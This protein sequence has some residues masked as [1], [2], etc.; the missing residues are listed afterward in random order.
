MMILL[1]V[2]EFAWWA[3]AWSQEIAPAPFIAPYL[4]GAGVT[5]GAALALRLVSRRD[6]P[7]KLSLALGVVVVA[8]SA[9]LFLPL[10]FAIP[11]EIPFWLDAPLAGFERR[12]L[13]TDPWLLLDAG[14][15][16]ATPAVDL[17]YGFW[18]PTQLTVMFSVMLLPPSTAKSRALTAYFLSWFALGVAAA[19][20]LSS[21]GPIFYDRLQ[22]GSDFS[23]LAEALRARGATF[24]V[25]ESDAMWVAYAED[26]PSL[27]SG[28]SAMPS[29]HVAI[30][31]WIFLAARILAPPL[32]WVALAYFLFVWIAS[33][34]LGWHYVLDGAVGALG[35]LVIW[36]LAGPIERRI[37]HG[38]AARSGETK[39][40]LAP[41]EKSLSRE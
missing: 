32:R 13:G 41:T 8:L 6:L 23:G 26:R 9:S 27:V 36:A 5:F 3:I 1:A 28:I 22:G 10:K 29:L 39:A 21:A 16:W 24:A 33:V 30:S 7:S 19:A 14:F 15:G 17:I 18:L 38:K 12:I 20:L 31:F 25:R 4:A 2:V 35:V 11:K 37:A 40:R 34:Q